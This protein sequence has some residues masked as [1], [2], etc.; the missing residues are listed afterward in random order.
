MKNEDTKPD[1]R[2][3]PHFLSEALILYILPTDDLKRPNKMADVFLGDLALHFG[4][5]RGGPSTCPPCTPTDLTL[6]SSSQLMLLPMPISIYAKSLLL[7][8]I[9]GA[10]S[11]HLVVPGVPAA[12]RVLAIPGG[13][14]LARPEGP[15]CP[16]VLGGQGRLRGDRDID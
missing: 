15:A 13:P 4:P 12:Q 2:N 14:A 16:A 6:Q 9:M 1:S 11:S 10:F 8:I 7:S 3:S 5:D